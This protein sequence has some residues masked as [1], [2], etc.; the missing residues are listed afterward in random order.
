[1]GNN[2]LGIDIGATKTIFL[3]A[4]F[5]DGGRFEVLEERRFAT[6]RSEKEI[7]DL[8]EEKAKEFIKK[9]GVFTIGI[10]FAGPVDF[11]RG[12]ALAGPNLGIGKI[13]F[14]KALEKKLS[15]LSDLSAKK[16]TVVVD[17]DAHC[18][19]LA[20][21]AF[22]AAKGYK[23]IAGLTIG[24]GVGAGIIIDGKIYR[25]ANGF[26]GEVGHANAG[27]LLE[28]ETTGSGRGLSRIYKRL[29][30]READSYEIVKL[31]RQGDSLAI[32]TVKI[33]AQNL[34]VVIANI[35]EFL[36]PEIIVLGGGLAEENLIISAAKKY[37]KEKIFLPI[38]AETP[39]VKSKLGLSATALG[40][41]WLAFKFQNNRR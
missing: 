3:A 38:L 41:A 27:S 36:N 25:G 20:E 16:I 37:A 2:I 23:N 17:N 11:K 14:K 9:Y 30:G 28:A 29:A 19:V 21:S 1:M 12:A 8:A 10:G 18:F 13:E 35:I 26:A 24:T 33:S 22:G 39:I 7:L 4:R 15:F 5:L 32:K 31:A 6:P 40:A 34:G